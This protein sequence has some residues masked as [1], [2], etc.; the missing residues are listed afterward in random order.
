MI[1]LSEYHL[2]IVAYSGGKDSTACVLDL[3]DRGVP[4]ER[5][6]LWHHD[7]DGRG[8]R[9]MDWPC[10]P[11]YCRAFAGAMNATI[12]YSWR[13]GGFLRE[14]MRDG[15]AT[16]PVAFETSK[17]IV[18]VGGNGPAATRLKFPQVGAITSGRWCS[19]VL[20]IDVARRVFANDWRFESGKFLLVTGE[21][22]EESKTRAKY[23]EFEEHNS[24][25]SK[26]TVHQWRPVIDWPER[27]VW[28]IMERYRIRPH[29]A[30]RL[31]WGR[32]SCMSC[33]FGDRDQ[34]ASVRELDPPRF[35]RIANLEKRFGVTIQRKSSVT[36]LADEGESFLP[37]NPYLRRL[38]MSE[39]YSEPILVPK[40]EKWELPAGAFKKAGGPT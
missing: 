2:I 39:S 40:S 33:I 25:N 12:R 5:I 22:R 38:A 11:E 17:E 19:P 23:Q 34:W 20:K 21:R 35:H 31:G 36:A 3:L 29:P 26:R 27:K 6:E 32:L 14:M 28:A 9:F 37:K 16:A 24:T 30:Y 15:D 18:K 1:D 13:E 10:T 4:L 7:V 8:E